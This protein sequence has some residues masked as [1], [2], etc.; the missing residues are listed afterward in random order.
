MAAL[1]NYIAFDFRSVPNKVASV[2]IIPFFKQK[3]HPTV[4]SLIST[5]QELVHYSTLEPSSG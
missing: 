5:Q 3:Q 1:L 2:C 4:S